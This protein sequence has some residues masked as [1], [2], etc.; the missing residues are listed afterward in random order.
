[1]TRNNDGLSSRL[2]LLLL[3]GNSQA[4]VLILERVRPAT[5]TAQD[6]R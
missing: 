2:F 4:L 3:S 6:T 1:M 5:L